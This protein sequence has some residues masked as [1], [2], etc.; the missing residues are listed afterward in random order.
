[1]KKQSEY[2]AQIEDQMYK[3]NQTSLQLLKDL[4][5]SETELE[6]LKNYVI[7]LK[8][9]VAIYVPAKGDEVD[10]KL[11]DFI[12]NYP[13]RQKLKIMFL[14]ESEGV[15]SFGSKK[16]LIKVKNGQIK[17]KYRLNQLIYEKFFICIVRVGGGYLS[18]DEF[19]DQYTP[20]ELAK[21]ERR[22]PL[23]R[24]SEKVILQKTSQSKPVAA[25]IDLMLKQFL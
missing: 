1:M 14:R 10:M 2:L 12:N 19:L 15:Y 25:P 22:D 23:K 5:E 9:K 6:T 17:S 16:I 7:D 24:F 4:K 11:A 18:I 8:S 13:D 21:I 20:E 3:A